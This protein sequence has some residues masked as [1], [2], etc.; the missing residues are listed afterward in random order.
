[1]GYV[2]ANFLLFIFATLNLI[3]DIFT[4]P[5]YYLIQACFPRII[6][7]KLN[8]VYAM[9]LGGQMGKNQCFAWRP[10]ADTTS[11][12]GPATSPRALPLGL[13]RNKDTVRCGAIG[14]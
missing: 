7:T 10:C 2:V 9:L 1:M 8:K 6:A 13:W 5:V 4:L 12:K 11:F 3:W 14:A